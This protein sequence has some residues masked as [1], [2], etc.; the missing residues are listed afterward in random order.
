MKYFTCHN[1]VL[2]L[3]RKYPT[4]S[5]NAEDIEDSWA[6]DGADPDVPFS[7]EYSCKA[8]I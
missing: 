7:N 3:H 5:D 4:Y 6:N 2:Y 8:D 1:N